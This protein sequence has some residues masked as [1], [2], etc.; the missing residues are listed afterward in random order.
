MA[1]QT[2]LKDPAKQIVCRSGIM[3]APT[4]S[5]WNDD[6]LDELSHRTDGGFKEVKAEMRE[7]FAQVDQR[8]EKVDQRFKTV[9]QEFKAVRQEMKAGFS[10][11]DDQFQRL[12]L[13]LIIASVGIIGAGIFG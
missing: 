7:G 10:R 12:S 9:D 6:R 11:V 8:F 3:E 4:M 2:E 13:T 1:A 5:T